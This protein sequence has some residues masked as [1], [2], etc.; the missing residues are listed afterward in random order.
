[1]NRLPL[2]PL[3]CHFQDLMKPVSV[4][5]LVTS[6]TCLLTLQLILRYLLNQKGR[7]LKKEIQ[8]ITVGNVKKQVKLLL[9]MNDV[10]GIK[11]DAICNR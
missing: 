3:A 8:P 2:F 1:M 4:L 10:S 6:I 5:L 11:C 9:E 7:A